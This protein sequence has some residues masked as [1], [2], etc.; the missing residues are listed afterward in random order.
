M[1]LTSSPMVFLAVSIA[2]IFSAALKLLTQFLTVTY[3]DFSKL[4]N[5]TLQPFF[6][7]EK[8]NIA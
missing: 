3:V 6:I 4:F 7:Q 8:T 1:F 2:N 5:K